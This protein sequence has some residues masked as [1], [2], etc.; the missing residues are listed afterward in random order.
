MVKWLAPVFLT[1]A[2]CFGT[3]CMKS[4]TT[5]GSFESSSKTVSAPFKSSSKSSKSSSDDSGSE[6]TPAPA[7]SAY[8]RDVRQYTASWAATTSDTDGLQRDLARIAAE[9]GVTDWEQ[10]D[11][12]YA[13][14]G[15]GLGQGAED[16]EH[17]LQLAVELA[18][19]DFHRLDLI[20]AGYEATNGR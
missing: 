3:G 18:D 8:E 5:Q 15:R 7:E 14:I 4:S 2:L 1:L 10:H 16:R 11:E 12:T 19:Q 17:A 20:R 9:Y 6:T 13:A